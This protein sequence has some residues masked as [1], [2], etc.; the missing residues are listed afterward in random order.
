[1]KSKLININITMMKEYE[2]QNWYHFFLQV[3][4]ILFLN[5]I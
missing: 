2:K 4:N 5:K 3:F 1:M